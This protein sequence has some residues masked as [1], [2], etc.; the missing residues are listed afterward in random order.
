PPPPL[1]PH[2]SL[3]RLRSQGF[4]VSDYPVPRE[5]LR[6]QSAHQRNPHRGPAAAFADPLALL[7]SGKTN[8]AH[9]RGKPMARGAD[10]LVELVARHAHGQTLLLVSR[11]RSGS[12][13]FRGIT[14][15]AATPMARSGS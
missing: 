2:D 1:P 11:R 8:R 15:R 6:Q 13:T 10:R 7:R 5:L 4:S 14:G 12:T 9:H 3:S